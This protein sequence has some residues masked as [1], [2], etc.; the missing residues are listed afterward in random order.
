MT[1]KR[2]DPWILVIFLFLTSVGVILV[3]SSTYT[4]SFSK[5]GDPYFLFKRHLIG[6]AFGIGTLALGFFVPLEFMKRKSRYLLL[7]TIALLLLTLVPGIS[8]T[9]GGANRWID[10]F[11]F[12]FQPSELAKFTIIFYLASVLSKRQQHIKEYFKGTLPP[13]A[14]CVI[15]SGIILFQRDFSTTVFTLI[16]TFVILYVAGS[17]FIHLLISLLMGIPLL[18]PFVLTSG[19]RLSRIQMLLNMES[20]PQASYQLF[21]SLEAFRVGGLMGL[22]PG[23]GAKKIPYVFNDFIFAVSG[24]ELGL[25]GCLVILI[26]FAFLWQRGLNIAKRFEERS[27]ESTLAFGLT[28][29]IVFQALL[30]IAVNMAII[31]PTGIT[32]PFISYG[33]SSFIIFSFAMGILL[34]LSMKSISKETAE[35]SPKNPE[36]GNLKKF[37]NNG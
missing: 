33:R 10:F 21:Q 26:L 6:I 31:F 23:R 8:Q 5:T 13:L 15:M 16:L 4:F 17:R 3:Y 24:E 22:G 35:K 18:L 11:F 37:M 32:L 12:T 25:V 9:A 20:N 19:Y 7:S 36:N 14:I 34:Q 28:F 1:H 30:N 27:F 2:F 29:L